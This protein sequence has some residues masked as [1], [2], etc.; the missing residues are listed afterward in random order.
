MGVLSDEQI[1]ELCNL[2]E[3]LIEPFVATPTREVDGKRVVSYGVTSYGYDMR[4][5]P[6]WFLF[7]TPRGQLQ[8]LATNEYKVVDPLNFDQSLGRK[9]GGE[10]LTM[11][12][13]SFA[14]ARTVEYFRIPRDV[15][16]LCFGKSTYARCGMYVGIT[17]LESEWRG[18]VTIELANNTPWPLKVY[19]NQGISQV[20]FVRGESEC[21]KSYADKGGKYQGQTGITLPK[22]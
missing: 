5:A 9:V 13:G 8:D 17:P 18:H 7:E 6:E 22:G 4:V 15:L 12:P 10:V 14:L 16:G 1:I 3:P 19:G 20:V 11:P 2:R 21:L